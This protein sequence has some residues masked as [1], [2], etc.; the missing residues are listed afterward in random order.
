MARRKKL[1]NI[2]PVKTL[3][4]ANQAL[5]VMADIQRKIETEEIRLNKKIDAAKACAVSNTAQLHNQ[6]QAMENGLQAFAEYNKPQIF[7]Q[8]RSI[9][10]NFGVI[11]FRKST[12]LKPMP[13]TTWQKVVELL[14]SQG[15]TSGIRVRESVNKEVLNEWSDEKLE[16]VSVKR[17]ETDTFWYEIKEDELSEGV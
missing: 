6:L 12:Q 16:K 9:F 3:S 2:Y 11:G 5:E 17:H 10:L 13:K 15:L 7:K 4:D 1:L 8:K 14:N